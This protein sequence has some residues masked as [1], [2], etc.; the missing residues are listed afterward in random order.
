MPTRKLVHQLSSTSDPVFSLH[1]ARQPHRGRL[2]GQGRRHR[3]ALHARRGDRGRVPPHPGDG[4]PDDVG[5]AALGRRTDPPVPSRPLPRRRSGQPG[6]AALRARPAAEGGRAAPA[7]RRLGDGRGRR[8]AGIRGRAAVRRARSARAARRKPIIAE[9]RHSSAAPRNSRPSR[10]LQ[11]RR[12]RVDRSRGPGRKGFA[13]TIA[14]SRSART[15]SSSSCYLGC[16]RQRVVP[17]CQA[18]E[19]RPRLDHDARGGQ[20][21][22]RLRHHRGLPGLPW[23]TSGW[24]RSSRPPTKGR[25]R[26][27][28]AS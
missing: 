22:G 8:V 3:P 11:E 12:A 25:R 19:H 20:P 28:A 1:G 26:C 17:G 7:D 27:S 23:R 9:Q 18:V 5:Q 15:R 2:H 21:D 13:T 10:R 14:T 6:D 16:P 24:T 4:W